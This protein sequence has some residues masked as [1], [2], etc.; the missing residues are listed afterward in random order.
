MPA[1]EEP[2]MK[3]P[4]CGRSRSHKLDCTTGR[5]ADLATSRDDDELCRLVERLGKYAAQA[6]RSSMDA[7]RE[8]RRARQA[9]RE[10]ETLRDQLT[11]TG[12]T[13]ERELREEIARL[14]SELSAVRARATEAERKAAHFDGQLKKLLYRRH[15]VSAAPEGDLA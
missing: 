2:T 5:A 11:A 15:D 1:E 14:R 6:A 8:G 10:N 13:T 3:C 9:E 4:E 7:A 12:T